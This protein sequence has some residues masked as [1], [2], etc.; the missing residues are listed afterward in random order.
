[1]SE[2]ISSHVKG[3]VRFHF[4]N[5]V[6]LSVIFYPGTYSDG[7]N[8]DGKITANTVEIMITGKAECKTILHDED[9]DSVRGH[10][11]VPELFDIIDKCRNYVPGKEML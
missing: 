7:K 4:D 11:P 10:I 9:D 2:Y 1:M 8:T 6:E 3:A 5:G